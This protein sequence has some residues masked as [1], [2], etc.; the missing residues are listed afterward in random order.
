VVADITT[1]ATENAV[2]EIN[3][4]PLRGRDENKTK[5]KKRKIFW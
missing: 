3:T 4:I 1:A 5:K 2:V